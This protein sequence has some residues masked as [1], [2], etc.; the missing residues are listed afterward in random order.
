MTKREFLKRGVQ[1]IP[2]LFTL[3]NAFFGFCSIVL[4]VK[5]ERVAAI[6]C[7]FI[8]AMM[9]ALDGRTARLMKVESEL[10]LELDSL[11]D[12]ISFCLAPAF[13]AYL[14]PLR[15]L[16]ILGVFISAFFMLSGLFRLARFNLFQEEQTIFFIGLPTTI[17]G[18]FV[19]T[20]LLNANSLIYKP[21]FAFF[22]ASIL[23]V[24]SWLM[25]SSI[26]FPAFK[27]G[28]IRIKKH[29]HLVGAIVLFT[30]MAVLQL[31]FLLLIFFVSYFLFAFGYRFYLGDN[32]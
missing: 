13:L 25:V 28:G 9:D 31:K 23:I 11:S 14:W 16:G 4:A 20:V 2:F 26:K 19:V 21:W 30:F 6:Y 7:I 24:F 32:S 29:Y 15:S 8:S 22:L 3:G 10:G 1:F 27:R 5:G 17:A 18:C 12:A